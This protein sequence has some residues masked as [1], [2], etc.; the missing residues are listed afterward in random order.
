MSEGLSSL[1]R[2][3]LTHNVNK[4]EAARQDMATMNQLYQMKKQQELEEQQAAL[5]EQQYYEQIRKQADEMLVGDRKIINEKAKSLQGQIREQIK[6]F[7]G[8]RAK[9]MASGGMAMIGDYTNDLLNSD[10]VARF[11]E[12]KKN[13]EILLDIEQ[14]QLGHLLSDRDRMALDEYRKYGRGTITYSG[15][16]NQVEMPPSDS[17][18]M[19]QYATGLDI[20]LYGENYMKILGNFA[21]DKPDWRDPETGLGIESLPLDKQRRELLAYTIAQGW[22][23][24]GTRQRPNYGYGTGTG[25]KTGTTTADQD[26]T[27]TKSGVLR[28]VFMPEINQ[29]I[30]LTEMNEMALSNDK[31]KF[32]KGYFGGVPY[33]EKGEVDETILRSVA[34]Y[35]ANVISLGIWDPDG[36]NNYTPR[37]AQKLN[38]SMAVPLFKTQNGPLDVVNMEIENFDAQNA[39]NLYYANGVPVKEKE[40]VKN[41]K[42]KV[43]G[44]FLGYEIMLQGESHLA[45]N[46]VDE[47][48]KLNEKRNSTMYMT[49]G[50]AEEPKGRLAMYVALESSD[51]KTL[52]QKVD[53]GGMEQESTLGDYIGKEANNLADQYTEAKANKDL[54]DSAYQQATATQLGKAKLE[55]QNE[56]FDTNPY[57]NNMVSAYNKYN[58]GGE[59]RK[60]LMKSFYMSQFDW[61]TDED[62]PYYNPNSNL[63][64]M[65]EQNLFGKFMALLGLDNRLDDYKLSDGQLLDLMQQR[66]LSEDHSTNSSERAINYTLITKIRNYMAKMNF[67][68]NASQNKAKHGADFG[69]TKGHTWSVAKDIVG[70]TH[71]KG[72]V[73][74]NLNNL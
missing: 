74:V 55:V 15:L 26:K 42:Y 52:Y 51:G 66:I 8:S 43:K 57:F 38:Q 45:V 6:A 56:Y 53:Y 49:E 25:N 61:E 31:Y 54:K 69:F 39:S 18:W 62:N 12:N 34:K 71:A 1:G 9:F 4:R 41:G 16:K 37:G 35:G 67:N 64:V 65:L 58:Q 63:D 21:I 23:Q 40:D 27:L 70:P 24:R 28:M 5:M 59:M 3:G 36:N 7:G 22:T 47:D 73:D 60:N 13:L 33:N 11:K 20:L 68:P 19:D 50:S 72:G 2:I 17:I 10:E 48:G 44:A 30:T 14:K 32:V 46:A 29:D